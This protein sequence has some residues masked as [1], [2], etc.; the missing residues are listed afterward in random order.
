[1]VCAL[2]LGSGPFVFV[3]AMAMPLQGYETLDML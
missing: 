2:E 3:L 1:M